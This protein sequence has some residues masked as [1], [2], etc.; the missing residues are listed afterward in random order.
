[1]QMGDD[2]VSHRGDGKNSGFCL[3]PKRTSKILVTEVDLRRC[4]LFGKHV[5]EDASLLITVRVCG[6]SCRLSYHLE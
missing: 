5:G 1:M 2:V 4:D 6:G 3:A